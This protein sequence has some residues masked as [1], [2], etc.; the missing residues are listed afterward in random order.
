M[1]IK[2]IKNQSQNLPLELKMIQV[3][4]LKNEK[5]LKYIYI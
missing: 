5:L 2:K 3:K 1:L 4:N